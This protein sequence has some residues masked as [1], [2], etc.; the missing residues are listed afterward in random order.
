[1][2][3][4]SSNLVVLLVLCTVACN[5]WGTGYDDPNGQINE[6]VIDHMA[7]LP[8]MSLAEQDLGIST[9]LIITRKLQRKTLLRLWE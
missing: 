9:F 4:P 7:R 8:T 5:G 3:H 1:V 2:G 6:L